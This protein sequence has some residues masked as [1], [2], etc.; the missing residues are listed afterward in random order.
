M[1]RRHFM[2]DTVLLLLI[3][4]NIVELIKICTATSKNNGTV[5]LGDIQYRSNVIFDPLSHSFLSDYKGTD[6]VEIIDEPVIMMHTLHQCYSHAIIDSC[7]PIYF[8]IQQLIEDGL[9]ESGA[10]SSLT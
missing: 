2:I 9:M 5:V 7:F 1:V 3:L 6:T 8:T 4:S 10:I